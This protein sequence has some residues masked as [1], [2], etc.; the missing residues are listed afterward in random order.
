MGQSVCKSCACCTSSQQHPHLPQGGPT[1]PLGLQSPPLYISAW[2]LFGGSGPLSSLCYLRNRSRMVGHPTSCVQPLRSPAHSWMRWPTWDLSVTHWFALISWSISLCPGAKLCVCLL[3][4][5]CLGMTKRVGWR[6]AEDRTSWH[7]CWS[8]RAGLQGLPE[9]GPVT[10]APKNHGLTIAFSPL[11]DSL[12]GSVLND[13]KVGVQ[14][15]DQTASES[16]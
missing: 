1:L 15:R 10:K 14:R 2:L 5:S 16:R 9:R 13:W 12:A 8:A 11:Q 6:R 3:C 4:V 7:L